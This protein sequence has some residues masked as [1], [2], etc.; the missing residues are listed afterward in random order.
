MKPKFKKKKK[1]KK[2]IFG[3]KSKVPENQLPSK[4]NHVLFNMI[5]SLMVFFF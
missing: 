1:T 4:L 5:V 3:L 2:K